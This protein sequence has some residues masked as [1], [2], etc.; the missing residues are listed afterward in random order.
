M[1]VEGKDRFM[2]PKCL[3]PYIYG[4]NPYTNL[5]FLMSIKKRLIDEFAFSELEFLPEK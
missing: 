5:S 3:N 4:G 2:S 1:I